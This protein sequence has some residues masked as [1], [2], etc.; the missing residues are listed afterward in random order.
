MHDHETGLYN[1]G[2]RFHHLECWIQKGIDQNKNTPSKYLKDKEKAVLNRLQK[3]RENYLN[4]LKDFDFP[5]DDNL[6]ER[7]LRAT[8][9]NID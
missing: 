1:F 7:D 6:S 4:Y 8:K 5:F 9:L 3:Y 2:I